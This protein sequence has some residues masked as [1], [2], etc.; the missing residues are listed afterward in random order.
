MDPDFQRHPDLWSPR[1]QNR[2]M[3]SLII[4][5][6]LPT[7]S[8]ILFFKINAN[9]RYGKINKPLYDAV[10]VNL[11]SLSE[12]DCEKLQRDKDKSLMKY[13]ELLRDKKFVDI[14]TS[15]TATISNVEGRYHAIC[16]LFY[17]V[18]AND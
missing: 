10:T 8:G 5:I 9:E 17:G 15:K 14:I 16:E 2:L 11:A 7:F 6:P 1:Q 18:L 3:E 12:K 13:T 4:R